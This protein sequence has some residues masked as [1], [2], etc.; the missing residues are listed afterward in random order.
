MTTEGTR[1]DQQGKRVHNH[2]YQSVHSSVHHRWIYGIDFN[3]NVLISVR[4]RQ[5]TVNN[6][7]ESKL[8]ATMFFTMLS[9]SLSLLL[10]GPFSSLVLAGYD[11][12]YPFRNTTLSFEERV[13]V[14]HIV[15][16]IPSNILQ[17]N[18][19]LFTLYYCDYVV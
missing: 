8:L 19:T 17:T 13:K 14:S 6:K 1:R 12:A 15:R 16:N 11:A 5:I 4:T 7:R 3:R 2:G 18:I 9:L 10:L